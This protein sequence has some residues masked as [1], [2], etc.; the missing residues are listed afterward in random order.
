M[1]PLT[2]SL[3][4]RLSLEHQGPQPSRLPTEAGGPTR[5]F[6]RKWLWLRVGEFSEILLPGPQWDHG[7]NSAQVMKETNQV[8][9]REAGPRGALG[10][11]W[12]ARPGLCAKQQWPCE[13][14][15][16]RKPAAPVRAEGA[17]H[18]ARGLSY[19]VCTRESACPEVT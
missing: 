16:P 1:K 12:S 17:D 4:W 5:S 9:S 11:G 13:L 10:E 6:C 3:P 8:H 2:W 7:A 14:W 19:A 18:K 15:L